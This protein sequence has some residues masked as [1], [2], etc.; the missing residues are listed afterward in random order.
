MI[1]S[2]SELNQNPTKQRE[3]ERKRERKKKIRLHRIRPHRRCS[4]RDHPDGVNNCKVLVYLGGGYFLAKTMGFLIGRDGGLQKTLLFTARNGLVRAR[5]R[6]E[7]AR[8]K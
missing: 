8:E 2:A 5:A 6:S 1:T 7:P 3:R 4:G